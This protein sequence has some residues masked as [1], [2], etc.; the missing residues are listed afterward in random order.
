MTASQYVNGL[1][2]TDQAE[3]LSKYSIYL[4]LSTQLL[5]SVRMKIFRTGRGAR[6]LQDPGPQP[7]ADTHHRKA[8][9]TRR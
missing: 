9:I 4:L 3:T 5:Q 2:L 8:V 6:G 7:Y 1:S